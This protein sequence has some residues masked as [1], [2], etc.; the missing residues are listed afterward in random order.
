MQVIQKVSLYQFF[1]YCH[2]RNLPFAFY[3][4]PEGK[5]VKVIAQKEST[6]HRV[7]VNYSQSNLKG[8]LFSP[9]YENEEFAKI[10]IKP[11]IFCD[12]NALVNRNFPPPGNE[13]KVKDK[14]KKSKL[15]EASKAQFIKYLRHIRKEIRRNNFKKIVAGRIVKQKKP[16]DFNVTEF[17]Q[18][19][20]DKYPS[21][22][23]SLVF[24]KEYGLW[25]GVTPEI[26]LTANKREFKTYSLA[27]TKECKKD[28]NK[29]GWGKKEKIEQRIVSDYIRETFESMT[30]EKPRID[31]PKTI[32]AGN[33]LHLRTTFTYD[34]IPYEQWQK[35]VQ[36]LQPTPAVAGFPK[37][38]AIDFIKKN[39]IGNRGFY[40][41]Y[42]GP[43]NLDK[44]I[45]LFVNI[46][47]M[48]VLKN[49]LIIHVGC[50]ITAASKFEDEWR[51]TKMKTQ[52][53]LSLVKELK[54]IG[55]VSKTLP[56][57]STHEHKQK[58]RTTHSRNLSVKWNP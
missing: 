45:N 23:V 39:E 24:T 38:K 29:I 21:A 55:K 31:G 16:K 27:G 52:T 41:G 18:L 25:I 37:Q 35:V 47:C 10:I 13:I 22:F 26:L 53:L 5:V 1:T 17:F 44:E 9:F 43:V 46:R 58:K 15:N 8:F 19:L 14:N 2:L 34:S 36:H 11:E 57:L 3:R 50:G 54:P 28:G 56:P 30:K 7:S 49:K 32:C 33:L 51:E 40:S 20:C 4:L 42:L 6:L 48:N 12:A